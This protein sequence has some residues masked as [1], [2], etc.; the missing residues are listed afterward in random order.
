LIEYLKWIKECN[1]TFIYE[2]MPLNDN[3][4]PA[5]SDPSQL[6]TVRVWKESVQDGNPQV[7][8]QVKHVMSGARRTFRE[9][10]QVIAF[11][12]ER[13]QA[14]QADLRAEDD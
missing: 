5:M 2:E 10:S 14:A 9:W 3:Q 8:I 6:F 7:R 1:P 4:A 11:I 12:V 13:M